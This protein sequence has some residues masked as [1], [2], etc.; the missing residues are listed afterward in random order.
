[1]TVVRGGFAG[2]GVGAGGEFGDA[3][4]NLLLGR[5]DSGAAH[6]LILETFF[7]KDL[8]GLFLGDAG[9]AQQK[10]EAGALVDLVVTDRI[11]VD[12]DGGRERA[13]CAGLSGNQ[14]REQRQRHPRGQRDN[15]ALG[16]TRRKARS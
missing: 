16:Q 15:T 9:G 3:G 4:G 2:F 14:S 7:D 1:M 5:R 12:A 10:Q 8:A 6:R 11:L 13:L